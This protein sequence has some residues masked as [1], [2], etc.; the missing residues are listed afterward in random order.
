MPPL[1]FFSRN[2]PKLA[3]VVPVYNVARY[4]REC[5]DSLLAQ[6]NSNFI[7][8][9]VDDG[10]FDESGAILDEYAKNNTRFKVIHKTNGGVSVARNTA[11]EVIEEDG[12]CDY[13]SFLDPDDYVTPNFVDRFLEDSVKA[14]ADCATCSYCKFFVDGVG[15]S[16]ALPQ[17]KVLNHN[18][19][20]EHYFQ[21]TEKGTRV[22]ADATTAGFL[23]NKIFKAS[24][25]KGFRFKVDLRACED[26]DFFIRVL[27][28]LKSC[29]VIPDN[30]HFYRMR[31]SSL[32]KQLEL[33]S[34][35][36][37]TALGDLYRDRKSFSP[38]IQTGLTR[39]YLHALLVVL[40]NTL[41]GD[42]TLSYK[43]KTFNDSLALIDRFDCPLAYQD[44]RRISKL[45]L[46]FFFN[47]VHAKWSSFR[48]RKK[49]NSEIQRYFP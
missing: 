7:V 49:K 5:L 36:T 48:R 24:V 20:A 19:L 16:R 44:Q 39:S 33:T 13:I 28:S 26:V 9:A 14:D 35:A 34:N 46:G 11:L 31:K 30:L 3:I 38:A 22:R 37:V 25:I 29:V 32:S 1:F 4:L 40:T 23:G 8:F 41:I 2:Q 18:Q 45:R 21:V 12:T 42:F 27:P 47:L 10:S 15:T 6:T 17:S 43:R